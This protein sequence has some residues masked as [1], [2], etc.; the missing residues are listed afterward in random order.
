MN[1]TK[2]EHSCLDVKDK[3]ERLIVDP[4]VLSKSFT[5]LE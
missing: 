3:S 5:D 1:I 2:Y 4:G